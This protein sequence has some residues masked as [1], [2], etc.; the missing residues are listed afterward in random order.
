M[1][2]LNK[3]TRLDLIHKWEAAAVSSRMGA[4]STEIRAAIVIAAGAEWAALQTRRLTATQNYF[5]LGDE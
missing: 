4:A 3:I 5:Q 2:S 1:S